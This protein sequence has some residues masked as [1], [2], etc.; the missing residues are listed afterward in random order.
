MLAKYKV[1]LVRYC[2]IWTWIKENICRVKDKFCS[3]DGVVGNDGRI[4]GNGG[5]ALDIVGSVKG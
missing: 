1:I 5:W 3:N 4:L 2:E